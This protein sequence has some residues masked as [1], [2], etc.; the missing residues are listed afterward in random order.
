ML[1]N[2]SLPEPGGVRTE[3]YVNA[4][5]YGDALPA[6][7][8]AVAAVVQQAAHPFL[9]GRN[10]VRVGVRTAATGRADAQPLCLTILMDQSG[11]M[12][13][14]DRAQSVQR[15]I[16]ELA[17]LLKPQDTVTMIGF[18]R[19]P[20]LLAD[21]LTG[22]R[23]A[24]LPEVARQA[25]PDGG[26]NIDLALELAAQ[27][28][29]RQF[30]PAAQNRVLLITDG[31]ANLG[32][33]DPEAMTRRVEAMRRQRLAFDACGV[34]TG[35]LDDTMLE[36]LTR[37][38]DGRYLVL[39]EDDDNR[40]LA[41]ELA[42]AFRPAA[43]NVKIQVRFN[44]DRV[45]KFHLMGFEKHLLQEKDFRDDTVD[46]AELAAAEQGNALYQIELKPNGIGE[47]GDVA[48]R[49][50]DT[51][52]GRMVERH[53]TIPYDAAIPPLEHAM[54]SMQLAATAGLLAESLKGSP[55]GE[56]V[57]LGEMD[58]ILTNLRRHYPGDER[59]DTLLQMA[60]KTRSL[61][62]K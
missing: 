50:Q 57:R 53:W 52:T 43:R 27:S 16:R 44:P 32:T 51:A 25:V 45:G 61:K 28:A 47:I 37:K 38:G 11:S 40:S 29:L 46:A 48:V 21:R 62:E 2:G 33:I 14:P 23:L 13:R 54:P 18:A 31:A 3:D 9:P 56:L 22:D 17:G 42:G 19:T 49:F 8:E 55:L 1:G 30:N 24:A 26:T 12:E 36:A 60:A 35:G 10:L 15:A 41:T 5:D 39:G 58:A 20:R 7:G 34:G 59:V 4:M 6:R